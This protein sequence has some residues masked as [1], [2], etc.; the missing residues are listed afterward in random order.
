V[1]SSAPLIRE[2]NH[3]IS[4]F[5]DFIQVFEFDNFVSGKTPRK[6]I[7]KFQVTPSSGGTSIA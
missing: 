5:S 6:T 1:R 2:T 4:P 3:L 7:E